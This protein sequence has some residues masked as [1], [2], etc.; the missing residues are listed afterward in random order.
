MNRGVNLV[1]AGFALTALSYG[2]ARFAYGLFLPQISAEM[3]LG[4]ATAGW[5]GSASFAAYC[6]G[7]IATFL[8]A[9]MGERALALSA[10]ASAT[11]GLAIAAVASNAWMLG[12]GLTL[13]GFGTGLTSPPL[14]GAVA[15]MLVADRRSAANGAINAGTAAGIILSGLAVLAFPDA[16]RAIYGIFACLGLGITF[17][18]WCALP[19]CEAADRRTPRDVWVSGA[20]T[21]CISA[22]LMGAASTAVWTFGATI[23]R[24]TARFSDTRI[25]SAWLVLGTVGL[26]GGVTGLLVDRFGIMQVHRLSLALMA[27]SM[28]ALIGAPSAAVLGYIAAAMFG[29]GYIVSSG[30]YLLWGISLYERSPDIG[31]GLPFLLLAVGQTVGAGGFGLI[32]GTVGF[33]GAILVCIAL[34]GC[35]GGLGRGRAFSC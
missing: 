35:A 22:V 18:I 23:L 5:I 12:I 2:L 17:W 27:G 31:L 29:L 19:P 24:E 30:V 16:W 9:Q 20:G 33:D 10:A 32:A 7:V 6:L 14:A 26:L 4:V 3:S 25:A 15:R 8:A 1:A 34:L 11:A 21:L 13:G 28:V